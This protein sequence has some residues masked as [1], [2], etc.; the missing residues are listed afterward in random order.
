MGALTALILTSIVIPAPEM[1]TVFASLVIIGLSMCASI[2]AQA[3][4]TMETAKL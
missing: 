3:V 1:L 2:L 4:Q